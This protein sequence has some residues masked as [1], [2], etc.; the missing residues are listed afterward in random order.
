MR[1]PDPPRLNLAADPGSAFVAPTRVGRSDVALIEAATTAFRTLDYQ[2]GGGSCREA[3]LAQ[4]NWGQRLLGAEGTESVR[5]RLFAALADLHN[6]AGWL[7]FDTGLTGSARDHFDRALELAKLADNNALVANILYRMGRVY[8]HHR[9]PAEAL[10]LFGL[11]H[12]AAVQAGSALA[13]A[14]L[15]TNQAW[16][17]AIAGSES[18]AI[19]TLGLAADEFERAD[20]A[21]AP[22]WARFFTATDMSAMTGTVHTE[23]ALTVSPRHT[24]RA[25]PA[26]A[27]ALAHY[28]DDMTRSRAFVL[29]SLAVN[30]LLDNDVDEAAKVAE[31]AM[32]VADQVRSVRTRD[33]MRPLRVEADRRRDRSEAGEL[34][35]RIAL[36]SVSAP[37]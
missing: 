21:T 26:L 13:R 6:L 29:I 24:A 32:G 23:L 28:G 17:H 12:T 22:S 34:A 5:A 8:L 36:F 7:C 3:V 14:I 31:E 27:T 9:A 2:Y 30:H 33:R 35:A 16:A 18:E 37:N 25:I 4:L 1:V 19:A 15:Y 11:G 20:A 10:T